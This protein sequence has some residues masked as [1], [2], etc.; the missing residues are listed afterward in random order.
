MNN[1]KEAPFHVQVAIQ[2]WLRPALTPVSANIDYARFKATLDDI[3]EVLSDGRLEAQ[4]IDLV[5]EDFESS[6]PAARAR[7]GRFAVE[8]LRLEV[9]RHLLGMPSFREFSRTVCASDLLSDFCGVRHLDGI[10]GAAKSTL[11]RRSKLFAEEQLRQL[12]RTLTELC[13]NADLSA[14]IGLEEPI[15]MEVCLVDG[16]CLE[17]NIHYPV[18]WILLRD[19]SLTLLKA[20]KLI[21]EAGLPWR[22]PE[23]PEAL[24]RAMNRLCIEMTHARGTKEAKKKRKNVLRRMKKLLR[25]IGAHA[26]RHRDRLDGDWSLTRFSRREAD[27]V[28]ERVDGKLG[29]IDQVIKQAHERIIGERPVAN[30]DKILSVHE[31]DAH[32]IV[33]GKAG[34][35]VEFGN[36][37]IISEN[38]DG[39]ITD[40]KL[41]RET[42]P[43][44]PEQLAESLQRQN[45]FDLDPIEAVCTDRGFGTRQTRARLKALDIYDASCPRQIPLLSERMQEDRFK[46]LQ[47]RRGGTE[48]RIAILTNRWLGGRLRAKGHAHRA[49]AVAWGVLGHNLWLVARKLAQARETL[50]KA[51]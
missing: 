31:P 20:I 12:H 9:L 18:D 11:E 42:A 33:R 8:A 23:C 3:S 4:A 36:T 35:T 51:A 32:V 49:R 41:Y 44:E 30:K 1:K 40:W 39:Y 29:Q 17:A 10:R 45:G 28:I 43:G 50:E 16:T 14:M 24:A 46:A 27:R 13:G 7:R 21:R 19:V 25:K 6:D 22:M 5:L 47:K 26:Q 37:L 38:V 2:S 48:A 34:K 15:P